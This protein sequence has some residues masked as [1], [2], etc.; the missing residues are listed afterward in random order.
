MNQ[1]EKAIRKQRLKELLQQSQK[2]HLEELYT[3]E[4]SEYK[5]YYQDIN[6]IEILSVEESESI[7]DKLLDDY[8][9]VSYG[10]G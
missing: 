10:I 6:L 4:A 2:K 7:Y 9:L 8:P 3:N 1:E 5:E